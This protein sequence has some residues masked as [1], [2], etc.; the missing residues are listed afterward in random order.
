MPFLT[1]DAAT[2]QIIAGTLIVLDGVSVRPSSGSAVVTSTST[3]GSATLFNY[4]NILSNAG[5]AID[6]RA[7]NGAIFNDGVIGT[8]YY[9]S[10]RAITFNELYIDDTFSIENTANGQIIG[11]IDINGFPIDAGIPRPADNDALITITNAG[12]ISAPMDIYDNNTNSAVRLIYMPADVVIENSGTISGETA[13]YWNSDFLSASSFS[14]HNSGDIIGTSGAAMSLYGSASL[15]LIEIVNSGRISS[16]DARTIYVQGNAQITNT[17]SGV[18][19]GNIQMTSN[20]EQRL[21]NAG[22]IIGDVELTLDDDTVINSGAIRGSLDMGDDNDR[23]IDLGGLVSGTITM[24]DGDDLA[25]V[26]QD[27]LVID[28]GTGNDTLIVTG[29]R[30]AA[31]GFETI[32]LNGSAD[33]SVD[34]GATDDKIWG[35]FGA[36][37]INGGDGADT[38]RSGNGDDTVEGGAGADF[39]FGGAGNDEIVGGGGKDLMNGGSGEDIFVFEA[40]SDTGTTGGTADIIKSF[41]HGVDRID[42]SFLSNVTFIGT[43]AFSGGGAPEIRLQLL[44]NNNSR[45]WVDADGNGSADMMITMLGQQTFDAGDFIL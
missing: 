20:G 34:G 22:E 39:L 7:G 12:L 26:A 18:I 35:N 28:G 5:P 25:R 40:V 23:Y 13:I 21:E 36:N 30:V 16:P 2:Q 15:T 42:M 44:T 3:S 24:G 37:G 43:G 31:S 9:Y 8:G 33:I 27:Y 41:E 45:I 1:S 10:N 4:G 19:E 29:D 17:A 11:G 6:W 14:L 32:F 38:I